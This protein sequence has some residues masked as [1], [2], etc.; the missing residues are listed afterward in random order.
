TSSGSA[1][2]ALAVD[3]AGRVYFA[4]ANND[5][6][7]AV[8]TSDNQG[9]TWNNIVDVGGSYGLKNIR[10]PAAVAGDTGRAAVAF[11]GSTTAGDANSSSLNGVWHPY[12][13]HPSD[14]R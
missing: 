1:D 4:M 3:S 6:S 8:G 10:F 7:I 14:V 9:Q 11:Y 5:N 12:A 13:P 2:P